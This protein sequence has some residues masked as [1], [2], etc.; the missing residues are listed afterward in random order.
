MFAHL[1]FASCSTHL[2]NA[3]DGPGSSDVFRELPCFILCA[4]HGLERD[5]KPAGAERHLD[6]EILKYIR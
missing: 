1:L 5:R 6:H 4:L 3:A 2:I